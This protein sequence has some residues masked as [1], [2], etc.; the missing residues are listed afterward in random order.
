MRILLNYESTIIHMYLIYAFKNECNEI[1]T[2]ICYKKI[3]CKNLLNNLTVLFDKKYST[4]SN[5]KKLAKYLNSL[6]EC[7]KIKLHTRLIHLSDNSVSILNPLIK[8]T[9][10]DLTLL[11]VHLIL[12]PSN[13]NQDSPNPQNPNPLVKSHD[14]HHNKTLIPSSFKDQRRFLLL[15]IL[16]KLII[17][18]V[19]AQVK[20]KVVIN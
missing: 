13:K 18:Q 16:E 12:N 19:K 4:L 14:L 15:K 10:P 11:E 9:L 5:I 2:F 20:I 8:V 17:N 3:T 1:P 7:F 6:P